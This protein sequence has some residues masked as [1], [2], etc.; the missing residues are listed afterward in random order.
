MERAIQ[1]S[2]S[3]HEG[4]DAVV[5]SLCDP[6]DIFGRR[7]PVP[8]T[9]VTEVT[10]DLHD[11]TVISQKVVV[12]VGLVQRSEAQ[13][14]CRLAWVPD[15]RE[16]LLPSFEGELELQEDVTGGTVLRVHGIYHPPFG[17][18]GAV[19]DSL[20]LKRVARRTLAALTQRMAHALDRA[21][22]K[23]RGATG[24]GARPVPDDLR[25][26]ASEHWLG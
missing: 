14:R 18:V 17:P 2:A 12:E 11:G 4:V 23:H 10:A 8:G 20:A 19:V 25:P 7:G 21:C 22:P 3:V 26:I 13:A 1:A 5:A 15:G 9:Y 16:R 6:V 24:I